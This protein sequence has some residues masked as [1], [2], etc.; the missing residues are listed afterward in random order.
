[1]GWQIHCPH[2]RSYDLS[3]IVQLSASFLACIPLLEYGSDESRTVLWRPRH[4]NKK[5]WREHAQAHGACGGPSYPVACDEVLCTFRTQG[6][7]P[8][9]G[10]SGRRYQ[11]L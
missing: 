2:S 3:M 7:H 10:V 6:I 8:L 4:E 9:P 5:G 11:E 1:M